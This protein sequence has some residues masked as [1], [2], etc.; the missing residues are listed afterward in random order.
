MQPSIKA[1]HRR[2]RSK[3][4]FGALQGRACWLPDSV[5]FDSCHTTGIVERESK[6]GATVVRRLANESIDER[7]FPPMVALP[8]PQLLIVFSPIRI[9]WIAYSRNNL[10]LRHSDG[11]SA[12]IL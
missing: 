7:V 4:L 11:D 8:P 2:V 6:I 12:R 5:R 9:N 1:T 3:R 10:T